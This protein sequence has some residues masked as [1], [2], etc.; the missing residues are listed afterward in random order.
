MREPRGTA[1]PIGIRQIDAFVTQAIHDVPGRLGMTSMGKHGAR[2]FIPDIYARLFPLEGTRCDFIQ[3]V[4][5]KWRNDVFYEV[6][7][8]VIPENHKPASRCSIG[9]IPRTKR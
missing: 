2:G 5:A 6:L 4:E 9:W 1:K 8:L 3:N 7:V